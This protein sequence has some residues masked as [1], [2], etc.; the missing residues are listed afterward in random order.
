MPFPPPR[1]VY[2]R[3]KMPESPRYLAQVQGEHDRAAGDLE[4]FTEGVI[5]EPA[6]GRF[7]AR[8]A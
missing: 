5:A 6:Q 4:R 3:S 7:R 1:V 8:S 2:L